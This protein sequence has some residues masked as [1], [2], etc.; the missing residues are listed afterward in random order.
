[1]TTNSSAIESEPLVSD[2]LAIREFTYDDGELVGL[3]YLQPILPGI[4]EAQCPG[5]KHSAPQPDHS[6]GFYAFDD[7]EKRFGVPTGIRTMEGISAVVRLSGTVIVG[8]AGLR[9]ERM[10][11]V[12]LATESSDLRNELADKFGVP[13]FPN[14]KAMVEV[15]PIER[16][17]R[18]EPEPSRL[19]TA[20]K[21]LDPVISRLKKFNRFLNRTGTT[22]A[23]LRLGMYS[24]IAA[25]SVVF[26]HIQM[27]LY[28]SEGI[29]AFGP[30]A[31][32]LVMLIIL[33]VKSI[34]AHLLLFAGMAISFAQLT[35]EHL[36][37]IPDDVDH[38]LAVTAF[39]VFIFSLVALIKLIMDRT[40]MRSRPL[41]LD[42]S[43]ANGAAS[44]SPLSAPL[45]GGG[46]AASGAVANTSSLRPS[47]ANLN[48]A[49]NLSRRLPP[50]LYTPKGGDNNG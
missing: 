50:R 26:L 43:L 20:A 6:C 19:E 5:G 10:E 41:T 9:A 48:K 32:V 39:N 16:I 44:G 49:L 36:E 12:A 38:F 37:G 47:R 3:T 25:V 7:P 13:G 42:P 4:N 45:R 33:P 22:I 18:P 27:E 40:S 2:V 17:D 23:L 15:F 29:N 31:V 24:L 35:P 14:R 30:V 8:E 34:L 21:K 46:A 1:M 28:G 11:V